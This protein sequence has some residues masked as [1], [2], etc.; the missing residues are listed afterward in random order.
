MTRNEANHLAAFFTSIAGQCSEGTAKCI[1]G[2][3]AA[4]KRFLKKGSL[5]EIADVLDGIQDDL[6]TAREVLAQ[7]RDRL[8]RSVNP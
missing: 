2:A 6:D 4:G 1:A 3:D 5:T 7:V 8:W